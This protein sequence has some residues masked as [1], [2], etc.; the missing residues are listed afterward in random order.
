MPIY[1]EDGLALP[2]GNMILLKII[3]MLILVSQIIG[4]AEY[5]SLGEAA[6]LVIG[7]FWFACYLKCEG[8]E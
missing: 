1:Q 2:D 5:Y 4:T 7:I 8:Y 3:F 6:R